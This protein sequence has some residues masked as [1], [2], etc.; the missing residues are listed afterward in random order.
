MIHP[1][2]QF[3]RELGLWISQSSQNIVD[4]QTEIKLINIYYTHCS[5]ASNHLK[6]QILP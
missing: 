2:I 5:S 4:L 3:Q 1:S 6:L